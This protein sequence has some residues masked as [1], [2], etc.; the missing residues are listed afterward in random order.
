MTTDPDLDF[1]P[2]PGSRIPDPDPQHWTT[3]SQGMTDG[4][5]NYTR[6]ISGYC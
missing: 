3:G 6:P 1:L 5:G 4:L 2:I